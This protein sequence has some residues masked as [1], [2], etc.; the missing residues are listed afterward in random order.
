MKI[1]RK[2]DAIHKNKPDG[3]RVDYYFQKEYEIHYNIILPG[4][5]QEWHSHNIIEEVIYI[6]E[7]QLEVRWLD[8]NIKNKEIVNAGD[9]I[10][11]ENSVHTFTNSGQDNTSFIV[12]KLIL[13]SKDNSSIFKE[14]KIPASK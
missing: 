14:D 4:T 12:F 10:R 7:G 5:T 9:M 13:N 1:I 8:K 2:K 6:F 11:V 3:T